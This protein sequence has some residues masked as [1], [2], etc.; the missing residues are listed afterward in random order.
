MRS[1]SQNNRISALGGI[2]ISHPKALSVRLVVLAIVLVVS[3][4]VLSD[5][6]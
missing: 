4:I 5:M 3:N 2:M 6:S 1:N